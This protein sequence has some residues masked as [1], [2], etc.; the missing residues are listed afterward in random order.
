MFFSDV[1]SGEAWQPESAARYNAVNLLLRTG[2]FTDVPENMPPDSVDVFNASP[3][4][5]S[6]L[7]QTRFIPEKKFSVRRFSFLTLRKK[8]IRNRC[9]GNSRP[10]SPTS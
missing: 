10:M 6:A 4:D 9:A 2:N 1:S 5:I 3:A 7:T 8:R